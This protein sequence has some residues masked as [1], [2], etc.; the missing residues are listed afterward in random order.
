[1]RVTFQS[2]LG[3]TEW[4]KPYTAEVLEQLPGEGV[5]RI[6]VA[7]PA[8]VSDCIETLEEI[9]IEGR[10]SFLSAGGER[11]DVLPCLN[12]SDESIDMLESIV[13]QELSGWQ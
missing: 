6:A 5:K 4:L 7:M 8:F 9:G 3:P 2:R 10:N 13:T 11:C 12:D 1:M